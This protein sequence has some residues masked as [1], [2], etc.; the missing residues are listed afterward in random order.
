MELLEQVNDASVVVT[1]SGEELEVAT[2]LLESWFADYSFASGSM[3]I[4]G[5]QNPE[6]TKMR[7]VFGPTQGNLLR[8]MP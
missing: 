5:P 3:G 8:R 7:L 1:S 2:E 6:G 4:R